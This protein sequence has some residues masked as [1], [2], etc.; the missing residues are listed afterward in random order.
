MDKQGLL[1]FLSELAENNHKEW[2]EA[3]RPR[4]KKAKAF[5]EG[6]VGELIAKTAVF[7]PPLADLE[8]K[9][10]IFRINRDIRFSKNKNPYKTNVGAVIA[11][12]GRKSPYACYYIHVQPGN[13]FRAGG[14]YH[15]ESKILKAVRQEID[16]S[17]D[18]LKEII[19]SE[20]FKKHF[21]EVAGESLKTAP[22]GYPKDHEHIELLRKK[23][24]LVTEKVSDADFLRDDFIEKTV[25]VYESMK[26]FNDFFNV[27]VKEQQELGKAVS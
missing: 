16:Y 3:N 19:E 15:P 26:P 14:I 21:P 17:G 2:M 27:V 13:I 11:Q 18:K 1:D 12:G 7:E 4:Y 10:C 20:D 22:K 9:K 23:S 25:G 24:F 8:P 5:F 6:L